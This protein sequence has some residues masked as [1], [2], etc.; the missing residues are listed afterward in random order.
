MLVRI[1]KDRFPGIPEW[2]HEA[3]PFEVHAFEVAGETMRFVDEGPRDAPA[4]VM[5]HG[6]PAWS[7]LF[8]DAIFRMRDTTRVIAP[9]MVGFG[10]SSK[11]EA[12]SYHTLE[13]HT[14]NLAAFLD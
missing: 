8:R 13:R 5:V 2:L 6:S 10:L 14:A 9:D 3:Y 7:F 4:F 1:M 11:P 12:A